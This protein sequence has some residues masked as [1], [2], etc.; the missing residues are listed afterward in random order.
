MSWKPRRDSRLKLRCAHVIRPVY[1]SLLEYCW[2]FTYLRARENMLRSRYRNPKY[3]REQEEGW[4]LTQPSSYA[5]TTSIIACLTILD[6]SCY[7]TWVYYVS[8]SKIKQS[9]ICIWEFELPQINLLVAYIQ[10]WSNLLILVTILRVFIVFVWLFF[11]VQG[12]K[13][14]PSR[15]FKLENCI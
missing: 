13:L 11:L 8:F 12:N 10:I 4:S 14:N 6:S 3:D 7:F 5:L 9:I 2:H 15:K 1:L